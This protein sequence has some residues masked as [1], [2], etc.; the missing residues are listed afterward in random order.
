V[1]DVKLS[2]ASLHWLCAEQ[3]RFRV[4]VAWP[5][6][7]RMVCRGLWRVHLVGPECAGLSR[8]CR[9]AGVPHRVAQRWR[10]VCV[11]IL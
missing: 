11:S 10:A 3:S 6:G 9:S 4:I 2:G 5:W 8:Q 7:R 1:L